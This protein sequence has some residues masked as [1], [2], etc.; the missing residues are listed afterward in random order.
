MR[1]DRPPQELMM[2]SRVQQQCWP[3]HKPVRG[4]RVERNQ[5]LEAVTHAQAGVFLGT[6]LRLKLA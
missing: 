4:S 6:S 3:R 1:V 2:R 5:A